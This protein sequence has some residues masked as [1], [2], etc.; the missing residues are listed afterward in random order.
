MSNTRAVAMSRDKISQ[1]TKFVRQA[2][3]MEKLLYFPIV[4]CIE[5][6]A[7]DES[8]DFN[9]EVVEPN[10]LSSN[11]ATTNTDKNIMYIR[12]DVYDRAVRGTPRDR[13]T[14]C[15]ELGHYFLHRPGMI[16]NARGEVPK[17]CQ[18][19]WQANTFAGE[20]MAPR[21]LVVGMTTEEIADKCG[22]SY[23]AASI[24]YKFINRC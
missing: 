16:S 9:Y 14:L 5:I 3:G 1:I 13:F 2:L 21:N 10:E 12:S 4:Q 7:A 6:M 24:Q 8:I 23:T 15:H 20:L 19:E 17:Y 22:M 18:P 11:Y